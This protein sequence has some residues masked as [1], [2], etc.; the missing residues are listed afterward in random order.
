MQLELIPAYGHQQDIVALF[1]EYTRM[2]MDGDDMM[3]HYLSMQ[4]YEEELEHPESKYGLP[5]GRLY[6]AYC[7]SQLAGCIALRKLDEQRSELKRLYVRPQFRGSRIGEALVHRVRRVILK[8]Y[9]TQLYSIRQIRSKSNPNKKV[10]PNKIKL[11]STSTTL[12][13]RCL[14]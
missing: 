6:L 7:D 3:R 12:F 1:T 13:L 8:S 2:L 11:S 14:T 5:D 9:R 4:G 10:S